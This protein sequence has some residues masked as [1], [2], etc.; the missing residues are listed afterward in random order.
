MYPRL[1]SGRGR[2]TAS[3]SASGSAKKAR[4]TL[5]IRSTSARLDAVPEDREEADL[6]AGPTHLA[7]DR[8]PV[9]RSAG[10]ERGDVDHR[11]RA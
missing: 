8:L 1:C 4:E 10:Q 2:L 9:G 6:L 5:V 7:G 3:F 11:N